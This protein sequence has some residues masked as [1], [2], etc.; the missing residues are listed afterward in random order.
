MLGRLWP[1]AKTLPRSRRPQR[2]CKP[3]RER[4]RSRPSRANWRTRSVA[5]RRRRRRCESSNGSFALPAL[6]SRPIG[7]I[8]AREVLIVLKEVESRGTHETARKLRT[9]IGDV[10]RYAIATARAENDPTTALRGALVTP[11]V[12]P[13]A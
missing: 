10:F 3:K 5:T 2:Q 12:T 8:T 4:I 11:T 13:R 6:G 9:A 1:A 7:D